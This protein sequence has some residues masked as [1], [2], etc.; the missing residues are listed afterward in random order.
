MQEPKIREEEKKVKE[1]RRVGRGVGS[2]ERHLGKASVELPMRIEGSS[3]HMVQIIK[4][5]KEANSPHSQL[6]LSAEP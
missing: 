4:C 5:A 2:P 6:A 1:R 3:S